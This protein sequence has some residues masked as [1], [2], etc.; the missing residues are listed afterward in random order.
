ML[1]LPCPELSEHMFDFV[2]SSGAIDEIVRAESSR[3]NF[4]KNAKFRGG[5]VSCEEILVV[6]VYQ[7]RTRRRP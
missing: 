6:G 4:E 1:L 7:V 5:A 2:P 3:E